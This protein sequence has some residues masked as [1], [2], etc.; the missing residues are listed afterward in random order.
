MQVTRRRRIHLTQSGAL[1]MDYANKKGRVF[2]YLRDTLLKSV[3][4]IKTPR[5][6]RDAKY[7]SSCKMVSWK[8]INSKSGAAR[9]F[10]VKTIF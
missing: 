7:Q 9:P 5:V 6:H 8:Q 1:H 4:E 3:A 2:L 10:I